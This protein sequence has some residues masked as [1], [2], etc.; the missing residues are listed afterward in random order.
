MSLYKQFNLML[1]NHKLF[2][3]KL[4]AVLIGG[5][6]ESNRHTSNSLLIFLYGSARAGLG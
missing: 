5:A 6:A 3:S 4:F 1:V 2:L